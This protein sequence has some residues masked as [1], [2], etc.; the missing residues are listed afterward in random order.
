MLPPMRT[1]ILRLNYA[2]ID[3]CVRDDFSLTYRVFH[4]VNSVRAAPVPFDPHAL[5]LH[6]V[7]RPLFESFRIV[8]CFK[9]M[10]VELYSPWSSVL[11]G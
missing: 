11:V 10:P 5:S 7:N 9:W 4:D 6:V 2:S 1:L 3:T 8:S